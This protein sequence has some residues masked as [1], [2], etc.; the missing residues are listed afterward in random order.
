MIET[1][2]TKA[3]NLTRLFMLR[4]VVF[5]GSMLAEGA[6]WIRNRSFQNWKRKG[7]VLSKLSLLFAVPWG[8][9]RVPALA[10]AGEDDGV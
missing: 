10:G 3:G 4:P 8:V 7:T 2:P 6:I 5:A 9:V 1:I